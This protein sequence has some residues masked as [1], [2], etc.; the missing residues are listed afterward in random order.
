MLSENAAAD[1]LLLMRPSSSDVVIQAMLGEDDFERAR[2]AIPGF[3]DHQDYDDWLDSCYGWIIG[4]CSSGV[5]AHAVKVEFSD[6]LAWRR[7]TKLAPSRRSLDEFAALVHVMCDDQEAEVRLRAVATV[8]EAEFLAH[9]DRVEAFQ[10]SG[11]YSTWAAR[12]ESI[13]QTAL[14][15]GKT[16]IRSPTPIDEFLKWARCLGCESSE[17][18]LDRYAHLALETLAEAYR[19]TRR[20]AA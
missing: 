11:D 17:T 16:V 4:L 9:F 15:S 19:S 3:A 8:N 12:R 14:A 7:R 2:S 10:S 6:F 5:D 13:E 18:L 20:S 1:A